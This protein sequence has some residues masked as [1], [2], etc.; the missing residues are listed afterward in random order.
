MAHQVP[1]TYLSGA[2]FSTI[3]GIYRFV[4]GITARR[5]NRKR[6]KK[7]EGTVQLLVTQLRAHLVHCAR[8]TMNVPFLD[9]RYF[10]HLRKPLL[11][12]QLRLEGAQ[13]I[14]GM[15]SKEIS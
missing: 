15:E 5:L 13:R 10:H 11:P 7:T 14:Q 6:W 3:E 12:D 9:M 4:P 2:R 1:L 8:Y